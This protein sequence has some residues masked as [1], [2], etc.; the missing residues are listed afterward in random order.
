[1]KGAGSDVKLPAGSPGTVI[2]SGETLTA[3]PPPSPPSVECVTCAYFTPLHGTP[4]EGVV[5]EG[6]GHCFAEPPG[7]AS[8]QG[9]HK[10]T[11]RPVVFL[12]AARPLVKNADFCRR[13]REAETFEGDVEIAQGEALEAISDTLGEV[14]RYLREAVQ[15]GKDG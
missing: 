15:T 14:V 10:L 13:W 1:V 3:A 2:V 6:D 7:M 9:T 12:T 11:H 5:F 8:M 4:P